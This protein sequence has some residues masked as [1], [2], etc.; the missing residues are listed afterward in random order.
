MAPFNVGFIGCGRVVEERRFHRLCMVSRPC[1]G[2][3]SLADYVI[4]A[5]ADI[6]EEKR[7]CFSQT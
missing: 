1:P 7:Q 3:Q 2:L 5:L 6:S 4:T